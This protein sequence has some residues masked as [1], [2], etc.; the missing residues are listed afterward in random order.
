MNRDTTIETNSYKPTVIRSV[1]AAMGSSIKTSL[2]TK[3][4]LY[5][6]SPN[7]TT[8]KCVWTVWLMHVTTDATWTLTNKI[9][10]ENMYKH[11]D[12][13]QLT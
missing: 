4:S 11:T 3:H 2:G 12:V 1:M 9:W 13:L 8:V 5:G 7:L 6:L 10:L